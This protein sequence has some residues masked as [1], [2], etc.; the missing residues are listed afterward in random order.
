MLFILNEDICRILFGW[1]N[2]S[3][4][5]VTQ[6][7]LALKAYAGGIFGYGLIKV[8]MSVYY[9]IGRT[10]FTLIAAGICVLLN[11]FINYHLV[12]IFG[13]QGLAATSSI[14]LSIQA[15]LLV[16]GLYAT[17]IFEGFGAKMSIGTLAVKAIVVCACFLLFCSFGGNSFLHSFLRVLLC[18]IFCSSVFWGKHIRTIL[19]RP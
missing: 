9:A 6:T 10:R 8:L 1:G 19:K 13:H 5:D 11:A 15:L 17:G 12:G 14:V 3:P 16:G 7:G 2:F 18:G 4:A